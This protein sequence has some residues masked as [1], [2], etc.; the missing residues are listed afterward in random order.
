MKQNGHLFFQPSK[1]LILAALILGSYA[2]GNDSSPAEETAEDNTEMED[3]TTASEDLFFKISLAQWSLHKMLFD[4]QLDALDFMAY[5]KNEFGIEAVEYVSAFYKDRIGEEGFLEEW[6]KRA[7]QAG[8]KSLIIM[9]DGEGNLGDTDETAR[10]QAVENHRKW[11]EAAKYLG[12]HSIRVNAAGEGSREEVAAA[13]SSGLAALGDIAAPMGLN[14]IVENHGGY[15]SDGTW[16]AGVIEGAGKENV[17]TLPDFGNFCIEKDEEG[18]CVNEYDR[19]KGMKE[20]MPYAKAVSAKSY[21]FNDQGEETTI[22]FSR[23]LNIVKA[24]DYKG[25]IGIEYE[26]TELSEN[27][28]VVA[29]RA[30]LEKAGKSIPQQPN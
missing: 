8:V 17:G 4:G 14:V 30:L 1:I 23:M 27:E 2:C 3:S 22:S 9:V 19:Y 5:A 18:G 28:G 12:C 20:L 10:Q 6:K 25:Y 24:H 16:L 29:T 21:A 13:A 15:S 7:D 11:L 26:G